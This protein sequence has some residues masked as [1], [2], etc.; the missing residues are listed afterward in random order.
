[1]KNTIYLTLMFLAVSIFPKSARAQS[2]FAADYASCESACAGLD[3]ES[4]CENL[5]ANDGYIESNLKNMSVDERQAIISQ[6]HIAYQSANT[7][8]AIEASQQ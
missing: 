5:K 6:E 7:A 2:P 8:C 4:L 3:E 1:M